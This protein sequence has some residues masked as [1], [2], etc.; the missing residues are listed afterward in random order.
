MR[1]RDQISRNV[2]LIFI[3]DG[4]KFSKAIYSTVKVKYTENL[5]LVIF[6]SK[7]CQKKNKKLN[8]FLVDCS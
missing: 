8:F 6:L 2:Y 5:I 1:K 3:F 4:V 7:I